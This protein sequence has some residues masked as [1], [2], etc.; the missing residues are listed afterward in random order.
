MK[1]SAVS[2]L[3]ALPLA[4]AKAVLTPKPGSSMSDLQLRAPAGPC[5]RQDFSISEYFQDGFVTKTQ[6]AYATAGLGLCFNVCRIVSHHR[7][8]QYPCTEYTGFVASALLG[9]FTFTQKG[10]TPSSGAHTS[11]RRDAPVAAVDLFIDSFAANG[12]DYGEVETFNVKRRDNDDDP[13]ALTEHFVLRDVV[14]PNTTITPA[15]YHFK[16]F[17]N[18]TGYVHAIHQS[19]SATGLQKRHDGPGFKYNFQ[20]FVWTVQTPQPDL[21]KEFIQAAQA[22][23]QHWAYSADYYGIGEYFPAM[24]IDYILVQLLGNGLRIIPELNGFGEGYEDVNACGD[25]SGPVHD[26]LKRSVTAQRA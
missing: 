26:E 9:V 1:F 11:G 10:D 19:N 25:M 2:L 16:A 3:S 18:G 5:K 8:A 24:G 20:T 23:A 17:A 14:H 6:L 22:I 12:F 13:N 21:R 7:D 15:D 4:L